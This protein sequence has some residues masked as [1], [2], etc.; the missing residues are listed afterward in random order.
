M[1][2]RAGCGP[3]PGAGAG[4]RWCAPSSAGVVHQ[5]LLHRCT[6][7]GCASR[8]PPG[9]GYRSGSVRSTA[10]PPIA[11]GSGRASGAGLVGH[12]Q[13]VDLVGGLQ[14]QSDEPGARAVAHAA[15]RAR[16]RRCRAGTTRSGVRSAVW[17]PKARAN[18][19]ARVRSGFS[20]SSQ[21]RS[22]TLMIGLRDR[23]G[24][25]PCR[26]PCS[27]CRSLCTSTCASRRLS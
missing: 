18:A 1:A 21:A 5:R 11:S 7:A 2:Q 3:A 26:A 15:R 20:N 17:N 19:S 13:H 24:C 27:L 14:R 6:R 10:S 25:S 4:W 12:P 22:C 23:P 8:R 16:R 9:P